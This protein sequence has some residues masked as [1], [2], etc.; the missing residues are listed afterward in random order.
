M[1]EETA[2]L[3]LSLPAA[4]NE[5]GTILWRYPCV[6]DAIAAHL[7]V[8]KIVG[9]LV[10]KVVRDISKRTKCS[11]LAAPRLDWVHKT[12]TTTHATP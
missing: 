11:P 12:Y 10:E 9:T 8:C 1:F 2:G 5:L 4:A 6:V 3:Q 7:A